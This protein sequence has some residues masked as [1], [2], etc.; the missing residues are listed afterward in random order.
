MTWPPIMAQLEYSNNKC[1]LSTFMLG[2]YFY[3]VGISFVKKHFTCI[4]V[5]LSVFKNNMKYVDK[6]LQ[7]V[8]LK[9]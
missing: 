6:T 4:W 5:V 8:V 2:S 9:T 3:V 1:Y 7:V